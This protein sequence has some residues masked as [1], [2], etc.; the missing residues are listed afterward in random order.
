MKFESAKTIAAIVDKAEYYQMILKKSQSG[1]SDEWVLRNEH[2]GES[3]ELSGEN[4]KEI[5]NFFRS[6]FEFYRKK[7]EQMS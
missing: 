4:M 3:I 2:T 7:I 6:Q 5:Q 1:Y